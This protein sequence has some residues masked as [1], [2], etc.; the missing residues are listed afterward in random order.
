MSERE[1]TPFP[2]GSRSAQDDPGQPPADEAWRE[3][4]IPSLTPVPGGSTA[5]GPGTQGYAGPGYAGPGYAGTGENYYTTPQ[6]STQPVKIRRADAFAGLLLILAGIAAGGSLLLS[7]LPKDAS[8]GSSKGLDILKLGFTT[9][10]NDGW[11]EFFS[12]GMW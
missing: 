11:G 5:V 10:R 8:T 1:Q 7:W 12:H 4:T 3:Q 9:I 6:Y 2:S